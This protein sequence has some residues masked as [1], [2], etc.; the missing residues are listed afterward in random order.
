MV[1]R[2]SNEEELWLINTSVDRDVSVGD[3]RI[4]V[5]RGARVNLLSK[6]Y[7]FTREQIEASMKTGSIHKKRH[8]LAVREFLPK[9]ST[10][11]FI[12][13]V[14]KPRVLK[15]LRNPQQSTA[16]PYFEELDVE[17]EF[18]GMTEE[19]YAAEQA[20]LESMDRQPSLA[21]DKKFSPSK[22]LD[23]LADD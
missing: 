2:P 19:Q 21:V 3:L 23:D 11:N 10:F 14:A 22:D 12:K 13:E 15:P 7:H 4:T 5:R 6:N 16:A 1:K 9:K 18:M 17:D 20:D 8:I